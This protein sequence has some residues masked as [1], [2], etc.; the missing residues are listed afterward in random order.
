MKN[1]VT[2]EIS[3]LTACFPALTRMSWD[4]EKLH[5]ISRNF[6][7]LV[8]I[9]EDHNKPATKITWDYFGNIDVSP[10]SNDWRANEHFPN[11]IKGLGYAVWVSSSDLQQ[12]QH[13][14]Q[15]PDFPHA[16][17]IGPPCRKVFPGVFQEETKLPNYQKSFVPA[18][19]IMHVEEAL[20]RFKSIND[21][22]ATGLSLA[23]NT[24]GTE[25]LK[26]KQQTET[27]EF[28]ENFRPDSPRA[29]ALK[30][31]K[32]NDTPAPSPG[33]QDSIEDDLLESSKSFA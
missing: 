30:I 22:R 4:T 27:N 20:K 6:N 25:S 31:D 26:R 8:S 28:F 21:P 24:R 1:F 2:H 32:Q 12:H 17:G 16:M 19:E 3:A 14:V 11:A 9:H 7:A 29:K 33:E 10:A 5:Q 13:C 23:N 18:P 15:E